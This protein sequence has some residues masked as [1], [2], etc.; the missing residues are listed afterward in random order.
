MDTSLT[1]QLAFVTTVDLSDAAAAGVRRKVFGQ[2]LAF[3]RLGL[4]VRVVYR[5]GMDMVAAMVSEGTLVPFLK[6]SFRNARDRARLTR[7]LLGQEL[8]GIYVRYSPADVFLATMLSR[9]ARK[10]GARLVVEFPTYP[11]RAEYGRRPRGVARRLLD[12]VVLAV[13]ARSAN[14]VVNCSTTAEIVPGRT[15]AIQNGVD[16][17]TYQPHHDLPLDPAAFLFVGNISFWQGV[18]VIVDAFIRYFE[19]APHGSVE[20]T[21]VGD[22]PDFSSIYARVQLSAWAHRIHMPGRLAAEQV[23]SILASSHIG[24]A[25]SAIWRKG[26][27]RLSAIKTAEYAAAGLPFALNY[28]DTNFPDCEQLPFVLRLPDREFDVAR[29]IS[30]Y[31][32]RVTVNPRLWADARSFANQRL[33]WE[34][35]MRPVVAALMR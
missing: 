1:K 22:G 31:R 21:I 25:S 17:N 3:R 13:M 24:I 10:S 14:A 26:T 7:V 4:V 11:Y 9:F 33:S 2:A 6:R 15:I 16:T 5:E 30:L 18:D 12:L 28:E 23:A 32:E 29:I 35:K 34:A 27:Q 20:L 19:S 8:D